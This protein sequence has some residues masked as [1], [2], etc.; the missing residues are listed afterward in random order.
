MAGRRRARV[1][2]WWGGAQSAVWGVCLCVDTETG[3]WFGGDN[4]HVGDMCERVACVDG[5]GQ[6]GLMVFGDVGVVLGSCDGGWTRCVVF[7][8]RQGDRITRTMVVYE[9]DTW[10]RTVMTHG[11]W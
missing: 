11:A 10:E 2:L 9:M 8:G 4:K 1:A 3:V 7:V 5:R 6:Q